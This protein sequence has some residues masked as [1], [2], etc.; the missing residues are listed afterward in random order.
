MIQ[1]DEIVIQQMNSDACSGF[2]NECCGFLF[3]NE[4]EAKRTIVAI[5]P[6]QNMSKEDQC[7][8]F[9]ISAE[10]Y[11]QAE[12][13][14]EENNLSLLGIYH[15]HP[16]HPA[17]PSETDR[18]AAMPFFSYVIISVTSNQQCHIRSWRLNQQNQFEE[19][20]SI[21]FIST[22]LKLND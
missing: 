12:K 13:Y 6:V 17:I 21:Q 16:N 2:P 10:D 18:E 22:A 15:S 7:R 8:R 9:S 20:Q 14:A 5:Q 19:E 4:D 1:L 3:G 11:L